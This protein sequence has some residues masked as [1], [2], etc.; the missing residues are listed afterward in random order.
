[1]A[2][3]EC[4]ADGLD[5]APEHQDGLP[6]AVAEMRAR[7]RA[8]AVA[9]DFDGLAALGEEG[10]FTYSFGE[11]GD[12]AGA[13]R[14]GEEDGARPL[15]FL[16]VLLDAPHAAVDGGD[17]MQYVWPSAFAYETWDEVPP[18]ARDALLTVYDRGAL[19][20]FSQFGSYIGYRIGI[21][22]EGDWIFFVVGD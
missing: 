21:T 22:A 7:I 15:L 20:Q 1:M 17:E 8:A 19:Q 11:S 16:A 18:A 4:S 14:D 5:P 6:A 12:P 2:G 10:E 3:G 13:W 9:C